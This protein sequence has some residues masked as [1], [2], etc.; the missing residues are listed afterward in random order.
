[1]NNFSKPQGIDDILKK[2]DDVPVPKVHPTKPKIEDIT[3]K[4]N[5]NEKILQLPS[6]EASLPIKE[7]LDLLFK[8]KIFYESPEGKKYIAEMEGRIGII[9]NLNGVK[10]PFYQSS[11]G[12]D[13]KRAYLW[14]PYFGNQ[15][16]DGGWLIK[17]GD[18]IENGYDIPEIKEM[19]DYLNKTVPEYLPL[20]FL[21]NNQR[22]ALGYKVGT[23]KQEYLDTKN[24]TGQ[25][26]EINPSVLKEFLIN[27][28]KNNQKTGKYMAELLGYDFKD[29][30]QENTDKRLNT[31]LPEML[32]SLKK[33]FEEARKNKV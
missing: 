11:Q 12:T 32:N 33:R 22:L 17:G 10:I 21:D 25:L 14:Y 31:F 1:M 19:M 27:S 2:M 26:Q 23:V 13:G 7:K 3:N 15:G 8:N 30:P 28:R 9:A 20:K 6:I 16:G 29:A 5:S 24:D 18:E 4:F